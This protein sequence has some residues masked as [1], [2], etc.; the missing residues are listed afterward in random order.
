MTTHDQLELERTGPQASAADARSTTIKSI[1]LHV[2]DDGALDTL[3]DN[4]LAIARA[5]SAHLSC[6]H[7]TPVEAYVAFNS[8]GGVFVMSDVIQALGEREAELRTRIEERLRG[9]DVSWD[10]DQDTGT[11]ATRI[12][13]RAALSDLVVTGR[14]PPMSGH[15]SAAT[16]FLG[17]LIH[18]SRTPLFI[19]SDAGAICDPNG[20]ALI[21]WDGSYEAANAVRCSLGLLKLASSVQILAIEEK[22]EL[23]PSTRLLEYLSRH[24]VHAELKVESAGPNSH[25]P[26]FIAGTLADRAQVTNAYLVMG[27]Y[28]R[29][30]VG[31]LMFGGVTRSMLKSAPVPLLIAH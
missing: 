23:F 31:E 17:D 13:S 2:Q 27:G 15:A 26:E 7:V 30:R 16:G 8:F 9:E 12:V 10:Y 4:G 11:I 3:L 5:C 21:A 22:E 29:S 25:D 18:R 14:T 1:L 6:L 24:G 28:G 20:A 19:P